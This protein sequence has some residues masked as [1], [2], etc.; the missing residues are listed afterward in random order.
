MRR[1]RFGTGH[2]QVLSGT[3]EGRAA[4]AGVLAVVSS[5]FA[6]FRRDRGWG[7]GEAGGGPVG[8]GPESCLNGVVSGVIR[9]GRSGIFRSQ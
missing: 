5:V 6:G 7:W 3:E 2:L 8:V 4:G 1:D 9:G